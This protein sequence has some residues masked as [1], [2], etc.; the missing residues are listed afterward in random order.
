[1]LHTP[2]APVLLAMLNNSLGEPLA[3]TREVLKFLRGGLVDV[4]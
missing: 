1:M 2:E 4:Y 3:Y